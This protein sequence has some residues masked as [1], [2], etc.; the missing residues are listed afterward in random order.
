ML[1]LSLDKSWWRLCA[2]LW[3]YYNR[4]NNS[5][6]NRFYLVL[7]VR[8]HLRKYDQYRVTVERWTSILL[9]HAIFLL[10][11]SL[12][13]VVCRR[14]TSQII[15]EHSRWTPNTSL[16]G[17]WGYVGGFYGQRNR[18]DRGDEG[19]LVVVSEWWLL[20]CCTASA[21]W[22]GFKP[23]GS[24]CSTIDPPTMVGNRGSYSHSIHR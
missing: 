9:A 19:L 12:P 17:L 14:P 24:F 20:K 23:R 5:Y 8:C 3:I 6:S 11:R 16:P 4:F 2:F 22:V 21:L 7:T 13:F 10:W 15:F 18:L 1:S